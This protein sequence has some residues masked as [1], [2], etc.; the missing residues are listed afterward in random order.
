MKLTFLSL[1]IAVVTRLLLSLLRLQNG[2]ETLK[3][4][5]CITTKCEAMYYQHLHKCLPPTD[6]YI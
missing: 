4:K 3:F 2:E 1:T 6:V 5:F